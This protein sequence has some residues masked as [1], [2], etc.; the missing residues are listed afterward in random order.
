MDLTVTKAKSLQGEI[1][2]PGDKSI[3][4]RAVMIGAISE[5]VTEITGFLGAADPVSTLS[6]FQHLGIEHKFEN[7]KLLIYG[8]GLYGLRKPTTMLDA[9]NSGTTIRLLSGILAGQKF[10]TMISGDQYLVKR[11][12]RRIIDPLTDMG[13]KIT[14][15]EHMTAPL[16]IHGVNPLK[17]IEYELPVASAQV[18]S[19]VLLAGLYAN[20]TTRVIEHDLSRDHT[21]RM[22]DLH[23]ERAEGRNIISVKGG[24][25]INARHFI[26][27]GDPSSA[28][29]F[30]VAGLIVPKSHIVIRNVGLNPTRIGFIA[31][32]RQMKANIKIENE[33]VVGGELIGDVIVS[34]SEL[35]SNITLSGNIIPNVIDEIPILSVA[36]AFSNGSFS[37]KD[38]GD[39]RNKETDRISAICTNLRKMG[40]DVEEFKD[41]FAFET[42][43]K[44]VAAEFDS[45][46]D[47]RIAMASG[48]A[49]LALNGES[50]I[51]NAECV[52]I[53]FPSFWETIRSLQ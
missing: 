53:S 37:V 9:G 52:S 16:T 8:K 20:G 10:T 28:A 2:V 23:S 30:I 46:D 18:K 26:V 48:I 40:I 38:A 14:A 39:L 6:C 27:P 42:K 51:L 36:G 17:A 50:K 43:N 29:F 44:L 3:S 4:H 12:M 33:R 45:F 21:E 32:L 34:A 31:L 47:H 11:P 41:G 7:G 35:T 1:T 15:A 5:G 24:R 22:L 19:A 49:A 25:Q 13:A